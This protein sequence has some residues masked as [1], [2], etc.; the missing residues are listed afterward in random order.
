M[1]T[2]LPALFTPQKQGSSK[3]TSSSLDSDP[4]LYILNLGNIK[5]I[6]PTEKSAFTPKPVVS[7]GTYIVFHKVSQMFLSMT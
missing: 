4:Y 3:V 7:S 6:V 1:I 5:S 2:V